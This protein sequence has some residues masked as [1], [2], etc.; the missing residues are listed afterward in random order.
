MKRI[1][2]GFLLSLGV[3][4]FFTPARSQ[5]V[6]VVAR[7]KPTGQILL[8]WVPD[9]ETV[10][11]QGNQSGYLIER[12]T[13]KRNG[14]L[15]ATPETVN[16]TP[17]PLKPATTAQWQPY[18]LPDS[19]YHRALHEA[20]YAPDP[21]VPT[22]TTNKLTI[23][24]DS[25]TASEQRYFFALVAADQSYSA[26]RLAALG[27]IDQTVQTN[28]QYRY[29]VWVAGQSGI[30]PG[31]VIIGLS[32]ALP[33]LPITKPSIRFEPQ[34][35]VLRW[36][37]DTTVRG[38]NSYWVERSTDGQTFVGRNALPLLSD[39]A[40]AD[41]ISYQDSLPKKRQVF[42]YRLRGKT[43]FDEW[44]Y[45]PV[46]FGQ[47]KSPVLYT[48]RI[49]QASLPSAGT[50]EVHWRFPGDTVLSR[51]DTLIQSFWIGASPT[52]DGTLVRLKVNIPPT[53]TSTT[54]SQYGQKIAVNGPQYITVVAMS[55]D[56]DTLRSYP[57]LVQPADS[58]PPAIPTGLRGTVD[59]MGRVQIQWNSNTEPDLLGYKV[60]STEREGD[61]P[62]SRNG[63]PFPT[64]S[65][66][67]TV[68]LNQLNRDLIYYVQAVDQQFNQSAL[69]L[70]LKLTRPDT[71]R[72][73]SPWMRSYERTETG[74]NLRWAN[75]SSSDVVRHTLYRK[76]LT[77]TDTTWQMVHVFTARDTTYRD[78]PLITPADYA[79]SILAEDAGGLQSLPIE[80]LLVSLAARTSVR[81]PITVLNAVV[82]S[83]RKAIRLDWSYTDP[84]VLK[85]ELYRAEGTSP[86]APWQFISA[87]Q[88]STWDERV[89]AD[90]TYRYAIRAIF[91]D[92]SVTG[93]QSQ[94]VVY[95]S[96]TSGTNEA[97]I[98][99]Q[100]LP[101]QRVNQGE[102]M[103]WSVP[104]GTFTDSDGTITQRQISHSGLPPGLT[105]N[106]ST[107][108][109]Q[110][111]QS[112]TYTITVRAEDNGGLA[113]STTFQLRV[114]ARPTL[115]LD[116]LVQVVTVGKP[117]S[118][119]L[120]VDSF[121]DTDGQVTELG[122]ESTNLPSGIQLNGLTLT[123]TLTAPGRF[124]IR[125]RAL[126][127]DGALTI[128]TL[129][130]VA[131]Q[132]PIVVTAPTSQTALWKEPYRY[133]VP[134]SFFRDDDGS[135]ESVVVLSDGLP[136]GLTASGPRLEG[137]PT[138]VGQ[139]PIRLLATDNRGASTEV[140]WT[141]T[142]GEASNQPP[143]VAAP[144]QLLLVA[145]GETL[146][147]TVPPGTFYDPDG[148]IATLQITGTL[149]AGISTVGGK[150]S[151]VPTTAGST[152]LT[153]TAIDNAGSSVST[154]L[155]VTVINT[156][157]TPIISG[158][159][160]ICAGQSVVLT[161]TNCAGTIQ[162]STGF[163]GNTI[164]VSPAMTT[165]YTT[166][167]WVNGVPGST[168]IPAVVTVQTAFTV[169]ATSNSPVSVGQ[170]LLLSATAPGGTSLQWTGP[171]GFTATVQNPTIPVASTVHSGQ[172]TVTAITSSCSAT[173][174]AVV[175]VSSNTTLSLCIEAEDATLTTGTGTITNDPDASGG[176]LIGNYS[177]N[178]TNRRFNFSNVP[179]TGS[180]QLQI[181]YLTPIAATQ[182]SLLINE[183]NS[184][185]SLPQS[186]TTWSGGYR[187][188]TSTRTLQQGTNS[189]RIQG[190]GNGSFALDQVCLVRCTTPPAPTLV[191]TTICAGQ[192]A[193]LTASGCEGS[194]VW[195]TGATTN[196]LVVNPAA[197]TS[198]SATCQI[199]GGCVSAPAT[200]TVTVKPSFVISA[201][202]NSPVVTGQPVS[203]SA[204]APTE[205]TYTWSGPKSF[206]ATVQNPTIPVAA[207][208]HSGTYSVMATVGTC[209]VSASTSVVVIPS[210]SYHVC[211][212]AEDVTLTTG[213]GTIT[214]DAAA[215]GGQR[216]GNYSNNSTNR[217][218]TFTNVPLTGSYQ[219]Q[220]RYYT[221][222]SP[223][224]VLLVN[225][226]NNTVTLTNT[227]A[228]G[229]STYTLTKT[230]APGTNSIRIQGNGT[231]SFAL[232]RV[233][234]V[235]P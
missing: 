134:V 12:T 1:L 72:P 7:A 77:G 214:N 225:E 174:T 33:L 38:F 152:T 193:T 101:N 161:A 122:W 126:D 74:A 75:S 219:F 160:T 25:T 235:Q 40:E 196:A 181:R 88:T 60:F 98:V 233:C 201:S 107:L 118:Y 204:T 27:F 176:K 64:A 232:D 136:A 150:L 37:A 105:A 48:P 213:T 29:R 197:T 14:I 135:I 116:S 188:H 154:N 97:P 172:Y 113:T 139:Y 5:V 211:I 81:P 17:Q 55:L 34:Q 216:I 20:L 185:I 30:A 230:L 104:P 117:F 147:Y 63:E 43:I 59:L 142:I 220:I 191:S 4:C 24:Q 156:T 217:R 158:N 52:A 82:E 129:V 57:V 78:E 103:N 106:G 164:T 15:L 111:T 45:S 207:S 95:H 189:I 222:A 182:A 125:V 120:A 42:Y 121:T 141:L 47:S 178:S 206:T 6:N 50:L 231:G 203:L 44:G 215:S 162:W 200:A 127:N 49:T 218:F 67:D 234:L 69:S 183:G 58:L 212:E 144:L 153:V 140:Q 92:G 177:N 171:N 194:I 99:A 53:D 23:H 123:G 110:P 192:S 148:Q 151:G 221:T 85:Y 170:P 184:T 166:T 179:V 71:L 26:A 66:A 70:P 168:S 209:T 93:W 51:V 202:S 132:P 175:S 41:T 137:V 195:N 83:G 68:A 114:N 80:P 31:D 91:R 13:L 198:Y 169:T 227:G 18:L 84:A 138:Q 9:N 11:Q 28:E 22:D 35:A 100:V 186:S 109:G 21:S 46:V 76:A 187:I 94:T 73:A 228:N 133:L 173:A 205:A 224:A 96:T 61:E 10:W 39:G 124:P 223:Q 208:I 199:N 8:R 19:A 157:Q 167:C 163:T 115:R 79:Y 180:Y 36:P 119:S 145:A 56:G 86:L 2:F 143:V 159:T 229:Y 32:D 190:N 112:G 155:I 54:I 210:G 62:S 89:K 149:P 102:P 65:W 131:N 146:N 90:S 108:S 3:S 87:P 226:G 165:S 16:L 128:D 130:L